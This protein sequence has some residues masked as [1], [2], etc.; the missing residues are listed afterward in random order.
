MKLRLRQSPRTRRG[1]HPYVFTGGWRERKERTK[2]WQCGAWP[3]VRLR[4]GRRPPAASSPNIEPG[5]AKRASDG[6]EAHLFN[7]LVSGGVV[8]RRV[9]RGRPRRYC[10]ASAPTSPLGGFACNTSRSPR[11]STVSGSP[12]SCLCRSDVAVQVARAVKRRL[13]Q[14]PRT[15]PWRSRSQDAPCGLKLGVT[16][17]KKLKNMRPDA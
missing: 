14:P 15:G 8:D 3:A 11:S 5:A 17:L 7:V 13:R 12:C 16:L 2:Q 4:Q 10:G 1:T 9:P 6:R